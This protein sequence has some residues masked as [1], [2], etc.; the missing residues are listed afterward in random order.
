MI[1]PVHDIATL[2]QRPAFGTLPPMLRRA[3]ADASTLT[4]S[5]DGMPDTMDVLADTLDT[6]ATLGADGD[7]L[8]AATLHGVVQGDHRSRTTTHDEPKLTEV[9]HPLHGCLCRLAG[10][11]SD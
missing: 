3:L 8:L 2:L 1:S 10:H 4:G 9:A 11:A 7:V 5:H 6:L